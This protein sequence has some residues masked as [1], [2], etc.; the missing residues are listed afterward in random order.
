MIGHIPPVTEVS[1]PIGSFHSRVADFLSR[2][3]DFA[4]RNLL[5]LKFL[6]HLAIFISANH[7]AYLVRFEFS[8]PP[9][10]VRMMRHTIPS[11]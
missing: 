11:C 7:V 2:R 4:V 3:K 10:V 1:N 6:L 9:D 8:I 5:V